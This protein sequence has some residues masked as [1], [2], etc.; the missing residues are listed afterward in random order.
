MIQFP[1]VDPHVHIWDVK[2]LKYPWLEGIPFLNK[3]FLLEDYNQACG[4]LNV[5]KMV[6]M[7]C[8][9]EPSRYME[10]VQWISEL[11]RQDPRIQGIVSFAPL[12][13]GDAVR[14]ELEE[15][16]RNPLVKGIRRLIQ[17]EEDLAFCLHP[18]FIAGVNMLPEF[19]F[20]FDICIDERHTLNTI[21]FVEQ[22]PNVRFML[23]HIGKPNIKEKR[24][25]P[26]R[27]EIKQLS[28]FSNVYC[29]VSSLA[30]E[31]DHQKWSI[32]NLRP[33]VDHIFD[34]FGFNR[35]V[36]AS[37]WPV[38]SQAASLPL[39]IETLEKLVE[40]IPESQLKQLFYSN[41]IQF[42]NLT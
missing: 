35:T 21:K 19:G 2:K 39:C 6:F 12:E 26:W 27:E 37:D 34:C 28:D 9:C 18:D 29:K 14:P 23:D 41:A 25:D 31:A 22:C 36:F 30:T 32:E 11:A 8:E 24:L 40:G 38:S 1:I 7:Q 4:P 42:Y 17:S 20:T 5:E 10:E 3:T 33:F 15:L 16:K 13:K